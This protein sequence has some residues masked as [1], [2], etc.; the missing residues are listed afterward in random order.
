MT[1]SCVSAVTAGDPVGHRQHRLAAATGHVSGLVIRDSGRD[2]GA[3]PGWPA[4]GA[5]TASNK[6]RASACNRTAGSCSARARN[7]AVSSSVAVVGCTARRPELPAVR[8][9]QPR[10]AQHVATAEGLHDDLAASGHGQVEG[11]AAVCGS[12][13][14]PGRGG[15]RGT[16]ARVPRTVPAA[17]LLEISS[18]SASESSREHRDQRPGP[19]GAGHPRSCLGLLASSGEAGRFRRD[20][21]ADRAPGDAPAA[22]DAA[23]TAELVVPGAELVTEPLPVPARPR[24][25]HAPAVHVGEVQ[26]EAGRPA[27]P[28]LRHARRSDRRRPRSWCRSMSG[29]PSCSWRRSGTGWRRPPSAV[30]PRSPG[31]ARAGRRRALPGPSAARRR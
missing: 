9:H 15:P 19:G 8:R 18:S 31:S 25:P 4:G 1:E 11:D 10:P 2:R 7:C 20:V 12:A 26:L 16:A 22:A 23:G 13:S 29:T 27:L 17:R 21:D 14:S 30:T 5:A 6:R 3:G 24:L 28:A